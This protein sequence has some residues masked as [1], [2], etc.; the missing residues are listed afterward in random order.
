MAT[1]GKALMIISTRSAEGGQD[2]LEIVHWNVFMPTLN[3]VTLEVAEVGVVIV[4]VP[5]MSVHKPV[6]VTGV[7]PAKVEVVTLHKF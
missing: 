2:P 6:P 4:P 5:A 3:P 7:F 1:V